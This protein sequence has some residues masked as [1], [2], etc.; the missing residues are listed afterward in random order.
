MRLILFACFLLSYSAT[1]AQLSDGFEDDNLTDNPT[2]A[3]NVSSFIVESARLQLNATTAGTSYLSTANSLMTDAVWSIDIELDFNPSSSNFL[4]VYLV[5][6]QLDLTQELDGYY[7][8]IGGPEDE[9]SLYKQQGSVAT[10][11]IDGLDDR[12][13]RSNVQVSILVKRD[14][15]GNWLLTTKLDGTTF[16]EGQAFDND[17]TTTGHFGFVCDYTATRADRFFF[18]NISVELF[19]FKPLSVEAVEKDQIAIDFSSPL[20]STSAEQEAN[21]LV[22][23]VGNPLSASLTTGN[24]QRVILT[25][26]S[27]LSNGEHY[28]LHLEG[29]VDN[30]GRNLALSTIEFLYFLPEATAFRNLV[31]NEIFADPS[32]KEDL[33]EVEFV[34]IYNSSSIPFQL[35]GWSISDGSKSAILGSYLMQPHSYLLLTSKDGEVALSEFGVTQGLS[36]FPTLNNSSDKLKLIDSSGSVIDSANY[37]MSWY[38]DDSKDDGGW[39]LEQINPTRP[40]SGGSNWGASVNPSGGTPGVANSIRN[41]EPDIRGPGLISVELA[42]PTALM[43]NFDEEVQSANISIS[44]SIPL[45]VASYS[46]QV[47]RLDLNDS[48]ESNQAYELRISDASDCIGNTA[49]VITKTLMLDYSPPVLTDIYFLHPR[50]LEIHFDE[51]LGPGAG[52][53]S[54]FQLSGV[55]A[56]ASLLLDGNNSTVVIL[57]FEEDLVDASKYELSYLDIADTLGNSISSVFEFTYERPYQAQFGDVIIS[58]IMANP[59]AEGNLPNAE[60]IELYNRS[61]GAISLKG[62]VWQDA[63]N[64][65]FLER[66]VINPKSYFILTKTSTANLFQ[67]GVDVMG[68]RNWPSLNKS[69]DFLT[70][71]IAD[72]HI[73]DQ[74]RYDQSWYG[75]AGADDRSLELVDPEHLCGQSRNWSASVA[76]QGGTPGK[77]NSV[78]Q[79]NPNLLGPEVLTVL[80]PDDSTVIV[81]YN[82]WI[83]PEI[84][85]L[86]ATILPPTGVTEILTGALPNALRINLSNKLLA[87]IPYELQL[88]GV[89]D[90]NG[91]L[92]SVKTSTFVLASPADSGDLVFNE[93]MFAPFPLAEEFVEI[94]NQSEKYIDLKQWQIHRS[95]EDGEALS[96]ASHIINPNEYLVLTRDKNQLMASYPK[97][98]SKSVLETTSLPNLPND[99]GTLLLITDSGVISDSLYYSDE[100]HHPLLE[101]NQGVSLERVSQIEETNKSM[102]WQSAASNVGFATP[103]ESNSHQ[104]DSEGILGEVL[105]DPP[106]FE[107]GNNGHIDFAYIHYDFNLLGPIANVVIYNLRGVPIKF[108]AQ[109]ELI[110]NKGFFTWDG[111]DE[112][113]QKVN[114]GPYIIL[115]EVFDTTGIVNTFKKKV[116][117][118]GRLR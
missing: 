78:N 33:P 91:N 118:G 3:G 4:R 105:I 93:L 111:T 36:D 104:R 34:E 16:E 107:P 87:S 70:L 72:G 50:E 7:V 60:Y 2:W 20:H 76:D 61:A 49:N 71:A 54:D 80:A 74:V 29:L 65:T 17:I 46:S 67:L 23:G 68:V 102:N 86:E 117:V 30:E 83:Q 98:P 48:I 42:S 12:V 62:L 114:I 99:E 89:R 115:F 66:A 52:T 110:A 6:N 9:V 100:M 73:L 25:F 58:E 37:E 13:N 56:P 88:K 109:N 77:E 8:K 41:V 14:A 35:E 44:P 103:G 112:E 11:I 21:Y 15:D 92:A 1:V 96:E 31:I 18:D 57:E 90:C 59:V 55:G 47:L 94:Y 75:L 116:V 45:S 85:I 113:N 26:D 39:T 63:T 43:L 40:C 84:E 32:P 5:S 97:V 82:E 108:L 24:D 95:T 106:V 22:D 51:P 79:S 27:P 10:K 101:D 38:K 28:Q 64:S 53:E 69:E 81:A 19:E